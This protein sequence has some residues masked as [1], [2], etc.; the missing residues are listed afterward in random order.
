MKKLKMR[1][2]AMLVVALSI[3]MLTG[4]GST[5]NNASNG[6]ASGSY[7]YEG[8]LKLTGLDEDFEVAYNDIY[9]METVTEHMKN[10]TS[11]GETQETDVTG[12]KLDDILAS[13]EISQKDF[14]TIRLIAGD[15]YSIDVPMD[16]IS[17]KDIV[18]AF[19]FDGEG[20]D[21]KTQPIRAAINDVRTMYWTSNL[22]EI[23]FVKGDGASVENSEGPSKI[24]FLETATKGL[25]EED[26]TYYDSD[27]KAIKVDDL[28][29]EYIPDATSDVNFVAA[30]GFEKSEKI[31]VLLQGYI[32]TT[33]EN[34]PLFLSP[35]LPKGMQVKD[36]L[37]LT[38]D[39]TSFVS[40]AK[41]LEKFTA[42]DARKKTGVALDELV[43]AAGLN[44]GSYTITAS[45][46]YSTEV[47][48][49]DLLKGII[50][51]EEG[52]YS[53]K[54]TEDMPKST[55][56]K[57]VLSIEIAT[58]SEET[59]TEEKSADDAAASTSWE[60]TFEGL[61]DGSFALGSDKAASKLTLTS[62]EAT[63]T[64]KSGEESVQ[65]WDGYKV[66]DALEFLHVEDF[67][68]LKVVASDGYEAE[69]TKSEVDDS[70]IL[71]ITVDG[72]NLSEDDNLVQLV[73]KNLASNKW[74][75]GV[76]KIIVVE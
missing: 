17:E 3:F 9:A 6:D 57:D 53:V 1:V 33:G 21:E 22:V 32:K 18:L 70:M 49:E 50:Y 72:E 58:G 24:V 34:V 48:S 61:S 35:D 7:T 75:K 23:N 47:T 11:A 29:K 52:Q 44:G 54:F 30:D 14:S 42:R 10:L 67:T 15:G 27:D 20:L 68:S 31:D 38:C 43:E 45:D 63:K 56:I 46:G 28:F 12:V 25:T 40:A 73:S 71:G 60:I 39:D 13:K 4:C 65:A 64:S 74:V 76:S 36:I 26:Y 8:S 59:S 5:S 69:F 41:S 66:L 51:E 16:I 2:V 37:V 19:E 62:I 55:N